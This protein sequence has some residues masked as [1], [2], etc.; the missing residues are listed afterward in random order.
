MSCVGLLNDP[1]LIL[2]RRSGYHNQRC[3]S[4]NVAMT[5]KYLPCAAT[6][7]GSV[8]A[9]GW[10]LCSITATRDTNRDRTCNQLTAMN[11]HRLTSGPWLKSRRATRSRPASLPTRPGDEEWRSVSSPWS[12][13]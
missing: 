8:A 3:L 9:S 5:S 2:L 12:P 6:S 10:W 7:M 4:L 13:S 11:R 1:S